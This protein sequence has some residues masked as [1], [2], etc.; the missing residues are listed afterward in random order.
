MRVCKFR[1]I[2]LQ[3][4]LAVLALTAGARADDSC[5]EPGDLT[6]RKGIQQRDFLKRYRFE[7]SGFGGFFASDLLS[8]S[9]SY[10]GSVGFFP[11]EDLGVEANV[12]VTPFNLDIEKPL[13]Q[14][15]GGSIYHSSRAE[16]LTG[17]I[18]WSPIHFK[19]RASEKRIMHGDIMLALG[20][21]HTFNDTV[22]GVTFDGGIGF[23]F[24]SQ[25]VLRDSLR[26][27]R[28]PSHHGSDRRAAP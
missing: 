12:V 18:L 28:L 27:A 23:R 20:A 4:A 26:R 14:F 5:V 13:T 16:I 17:N 6:A 22:Q 1:Y 21:G 2:G 11:F 25:P 7:V 8:S 15:F 3:I 9:Y 10:G 19:V 24:L